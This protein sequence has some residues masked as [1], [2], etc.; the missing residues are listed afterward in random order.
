VI[1]SIVTLTQ[2]VGL[3]KI[4]EKRK[5]KNWEQHEFR[6]NFFDSQKNTETFYSIFVSIFE[7]L[8]DPSPPPTKKNF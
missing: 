2:G 6:K 1:G 3:P 4:Y 7:A 8:F 5:M